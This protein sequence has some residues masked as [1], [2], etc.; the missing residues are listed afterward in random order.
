MAVK[1]KPAKPAPAKTGGVLKFKPKKQKKPKKPLPRF[2]LVVLSV[3]VFVLLL[4]G[5]GFCLYTNVA[6]LT[7]KAL[8]LLPDY[9]QSLASLDKKKQD[10][11]KD[12][13]AQQAKLKKDREKLA[14]DA[15]ANAKS[16]QN[17]SLR[18]AQLKSDRLAFENSKQASATGEEKQKLMAGIY[19]SL[20][21][22][23]AAEMLLKAP[24][25]REIADVLLLLSQARM[26]EILTEIKK[27]DAQKAY[28]ITKLIGQ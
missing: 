10:A 2:M 23:D 26:T 22:G 24:T 3:L 28:D 16:A 12:I 7:E 1:L 14:A 6:G 20:E 9:R 25:L 15:E 5:A 27:K 11:E 8:V 18:E 17:L 19:N 4:A 13:A 21:A